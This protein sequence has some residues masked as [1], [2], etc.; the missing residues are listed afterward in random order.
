MN[1]ADIL[2]RSGQPKLAYSRALAIHEWARGELARRAGNDPAAEIMQA[3]SADLLAW[4]CFMM[5]AYES[6]ITFA[7]TARAIWERQAE[8]A[9]AARSVANL[10]LLLAAIG[11]PDAALEALAAL[12]L[13]ERAGDQEEAS[14]ALNVN[15]VVLWL[16]KQPDRALPFGREA[17]ARSEAAGGADP[18]ALINLAGIEVEIA[19]LN[20]ATLPDAI[21]RAIATTARA[22]AQARERGDGWLERL[23][24]C[25]I[26]EY[27]LH[28]GA[29]DDAAQT[30]LGY[31]TTAGEPTDRCWAH[32]LHMLGRTQLGQGLAEEAVATMSASRDICMRCQD[33]ETASACHR[34]LAEALAALG[35]F[36]EALQ[37]HR[38]FH[39]LYV[40]QAREDAQ[41]RARNHALQWEA[42]QL[43]TLVREARERAEDLAQTNQKLFHETERLMRANFEDPLT[44]LQNRRRLDVAFL[45]LMESP[46]PFGIAMV[47][48]DHFK[49]VN[50]RFSHPVGDAVLRTIAELLT[51]A[52]GRDT[53]IVRFGGEEFALLIRDPDEQR[54]STLCE[55]LRA[56][57]AAHS[58][59]RIAPG[60]SVTASIGLA[61]SREASSHASVLALADSRLYA[62]KQ[63]GRNCLVCGGSSEPPPSPATPRLSQAS[64][65]G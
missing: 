16:L 32:Y 6:G 50:D 62:A 27:Q 38:T 34:D 41:R 64:R 11:E 26:A 13:A 63:A 33:I 45:E 44:G 49:Q 18:I 46:A 40:R 28:I 53:L 60:L 22:L 5:A 61:W 35:R 39:D 54:G 57:I 9:R 48:A 14:W 23:A 8:P 25:N 43:R 42:D 7:R 1:H 37:A 29:W 12:D 17:V 3:R 55:A 36:P 52:A 24:L 56:R 30:L 51:E 10:A 31:S 15:G 19:L 4:C 47:D 59:A 21:P 20:P 2:S 58:W 65:A